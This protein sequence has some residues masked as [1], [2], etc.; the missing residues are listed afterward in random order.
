MID[1]KVITGDNELDLDI[2]IGKAQGPAGVTGP[3]GADGQ[4]TYDLWRSL[5]NE[6]TEAQFIDSSQYHTESSVVPFF[7]AEVV[8]VPYRGV[9]RGDVYLYDG[10]VDLQSATLSVIHQGVT[11]AFMPVG[12]LGLNES[13][14]WYSGGDSNAFRSAGGDYLVKKHNGLWV[15]GQLNDHNLGGFAGSE[16]TT[17]GSGG[18]LPYSYGS[19]DIVLDIDSLNSELFVLSEPVLTFNRQDGLVNVG[20]GGTKQTG[21]IVL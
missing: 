11:S 3:P 16:F 21:Y 13:G 12:N 8:S 19:Y 17:L 2:L 15:I 4:S 10:S 7:N 1:L 9:F 5:G 14:N 20:F 18:S 6:G